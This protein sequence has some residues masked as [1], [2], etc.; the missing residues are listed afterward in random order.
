MSASIRKHWPLLGAV[1]VYW[2]AV[3]VL[4]ILSLNLNQGHLVYA[5]DDA[6]IHMSVA[7]NAA[8]H[9]VWGVTGHEFTSST[10]SPLWTSLLAV[11]YLAFG[12]TEAAPLILNVLFGTAAILA[13]Y[14]ILA[15][16]VAS[17]IRAAVILLV[18]VLAMPL[19]SLTFAGMEHLLHALLSLS[20]VYLSMRALSSTARALQKSHVLL[21][22]V[23]PLVTTARYEGVFLVLVVC[24]LFLLRRR[25]L[26]AAALGSAALLPVVAYGLWSVAHGWY[27]LPNSVLLKAHMPGS[28]LQEMTRLLGFGALSSLRAN[29]HMMVLLIASLCA[30]L[31]CYCRRD[32]E[33]GDARYANLIFVGAALLHMQFADMGWFFRYEAYLVLLGI[34]AIG[35]AANDLVPSTRTRGVGR[36]GALPCYAVA[37]LL[38]VVAANPVAGRTLKSL[39]IAPQA[40][41]DI[42]DQHYHMGTF[43]REFY[44][45]RSVAVNDIGAVTYLADIELVD[46]WGLGS[47]E[48]AR[49]RLQRSYTTEQIDRLTRE[50]RVAIAVVYEDWF[51]RDGIGA[52]PQHWVRVGQWRI[53]NRVIAGGEAVSLF[54]VD[55]GVRDELR[56]NLQQF[57]AELPADVVQCGEYT[58]R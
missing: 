13:S 7:K 46:L 34:I 1:G 45:G 23:A 15:R 42:Y 4:L 57:S 49:L 6:Y 35:I 55:P 27:F 5:L 3:A 39:S 40:T 54:A 14:L 51:G 43:L 20:F 8:L 28:D 53:T 2:A 36:R 10:S 9:N 37:V 33:C 56:R 30:L 26:Y 12:V 17:R 58:E 41:N 47:L 19:P 32:R 16:Y 21:M 24:V 31:S 38:A 18:A 48:P 22:I 25:V 29:A 52:L 50:R 44:Q 11:T